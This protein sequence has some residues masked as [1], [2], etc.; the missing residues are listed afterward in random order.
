VFSLILQWRITNHENAGATL[1]AVPVFSGF[2]KL[3]NEHSVFSEFEIKHI[4]IGQLVWISVITRQ[5]D[6]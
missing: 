1:C 2:T 4:L 6:M 3:T 5:I